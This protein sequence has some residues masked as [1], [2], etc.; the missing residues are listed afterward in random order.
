MSLYVTALIR[1][2]FVTGLIRAVKIICRLINMPSTSITVYLG[3]A[4]YRAE[5]AKASLLYNPIMQCKNLS[6]GVPPPPPAHHGNEED[7][8]RHG[9]AGFLFLTGKSPHN[10][11]NTTGRP[12][13]IFDGGHLNISKTI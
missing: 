1:S 5:N 12:V 11:Y 10:A 7:Y 6:S 2:I 4:M 8:Q 9:A 3:K 13:S